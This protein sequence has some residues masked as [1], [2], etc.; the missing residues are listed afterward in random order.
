M[1]RMGLEYIT[2]KLSLCVTVFLRIDTNDL[3]LDAGT[4]VK[5]CRVLF[6]GGRALQSTNLYMLVPGPFGLFSRG[7]VGPVGS[8]E[9]VKSTPRYAA[10]ALIAASAALPQSKAAL[11]S[12]WTY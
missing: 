6:P 11:V 2:T 9:S 1:L 3:S 7:G 10:S 12:P 8:N 5:K 4:S